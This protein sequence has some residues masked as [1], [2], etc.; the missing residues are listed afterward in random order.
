MKKSLWYLIKKDARVSFPGFLIFM[1]VLCAGS[2]FVKPFSWFVVAS[3]V[4]IAIFG[5]VCA[6]VAIK[7]EWHE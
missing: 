3:T 4:L 1:L 2:F 7:N 6:L 5:V